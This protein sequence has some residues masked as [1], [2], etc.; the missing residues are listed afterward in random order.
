[1]RFS[2]KIAGF[3][4]F[5][6]GSYPPYNSLIGES[7]FLVTFQREILAGY[8]REVEEAASRLSRAR[9]LSRNSPLEVK[10]GGGGGG[11]GCRT[12]ERGAARPCN[13]ISVFESLSVLAEPS[14]VSHPERDREA[15]RGMRRVT[16]IGDFSIWK[17]SFH[18]E[19][20]IG[21]GF[22]RATLNFDLGRHPLKAI[23]GKE[24]EE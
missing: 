7:D 16:G 2:L 6:K 3:N 1:M 14:A 8:R 12:R 5:L 11:G 13:Y 9:K 21:G 17:R 15:G 20:G 22:G 19:L 24:A 4:I 18:F 10:G 23:I